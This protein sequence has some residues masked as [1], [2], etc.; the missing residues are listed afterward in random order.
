MYT[1]NLEERSMRIAQIYDCVLWYFLSKAAA[2]DVLSSG[3]ISSIE[4]LPGGRR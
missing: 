4:K 3:K 1:R 2:F